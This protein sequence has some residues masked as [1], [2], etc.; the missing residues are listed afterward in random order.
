MFSI[1]SAQLGRH[2]REA[3][4]YHRP[5]DLRSPVEQVQRE[6]QPA[7]VYDVPFHGHDGVR[8]LDIGFPLKQM[9]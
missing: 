4:L 6:R 2:L 9:P 8:S 7:A 5:A 3:E 1:G